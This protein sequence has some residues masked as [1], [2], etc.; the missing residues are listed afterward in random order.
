MAEM[1]ISGSANE[2][3]RDRL[4]Q[5]LHRYGALPSVKYP[6]ALLG[7]P[8]LEALL[9]GKRSFPAAEAFAVGVLTLLMDNRPGSKDIA[10]IRRVLVQAED[11]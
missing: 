7:V 10:N 6:A 5:Q 9:A 8:G 1:N 11:R 3:I 2:A 4:Y